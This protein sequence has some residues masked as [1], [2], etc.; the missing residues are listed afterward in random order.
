MPYLRDL[1]V[2]HLYLLAVAAGARGLDARLRRRRP[3]ARLGRARRRGGA[4]RARWPREPASGS[5]STSSPTTWRPT[6]RT[7]AGRTERCARGSSTSTRRPAGTGASSTSTTSPACASGGP[8]GVRRRRTA[9]SLE[10]V[11][12]G[13][14]RRAA[15]RPPRRARRPGAATCGGCAT[16]APSTCGSRRSSTPASALRDWPVEGTVGYEFLNDVARAVRRPGGRGGADR[17]LAS[18]PAT[19]GRSREVAV[20]AQARAG[21]D[22]LRAARSSGCARA[23]ATSTAIAEALAALPV[24]RT[25]VEPWRGPRRATTTASAIAAA[26]PAVARARAAARGARPRRVRHALPADDAAGDGQGRRGHRVLPLRCGCSRST[27]SAATRRASGS[28]STTS[29]RR[30]PSAPSASR[31]TCSSRQTHD[32]KRS[33]DVRARIGALAAMAERVGGAVAELARRCARPTRPTTSSAT[34][35]SR[36]SSAPGRSS[37]ERLE[38]YV[39]KALREAKRTRAGSSPTRRYEAAVQALR[40]ALVDRRGRSGGLRRRSP[41]ALARR[42]PRRRSASCCSSS[43]CPACPTSTR[44][45]SC[46]RSRSST[47]TTAGRSTGRRGARRSARC[48]PARRRRDDDAQALA[49]PRARWRCARAGPDAFAGAYEPLDAGAGRVRVPARRRGA[50]SSCR[51]ATGTARGWPCPGAGARC[52]RTAR[53]VDLARGRRASPS[54]PVHGRWRCSSAREQLGRG[55]GRVARYAQADEARRRH[56]D[57]DA[58]AREQPMSGGR[59]QRLVQQPDDAA[60]Q[61]SAG[62]ACARGL[63]ARARRARPRTPSPGTR[64]PRSCRRRCSPCRC[65]RPRRSGRA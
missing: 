14:R 46:G 22:D 24:Y 41:S 23:A 13:R 37:A 6:T 64:R 29:T 3:D 39:E 27:R 60:R 11:R 47:P 35:S 50:R 5:C 10:L 2:S 42:R 31:A 12:D 44:A 18:S 33:G 65:P 8:G 30:T 20:E 49:H 7:A 21:D 9:R 4:P 36:R 61:Q 51:C 54:S 17:A 48:A 38:A 62:Q 52:S 15:R 26:A 56:D 32:T 43:P 63:Q 57:G 40:A 28:R 45:T 53:P 1:G 55:R 25:Y 58:Q 59:R 34:W 19:R 16:P